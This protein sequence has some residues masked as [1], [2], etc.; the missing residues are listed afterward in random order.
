VAARRREQR[1]AA[2]WAALHEA[3]AAAEAARPRFAFAAADASPAAELA[4]LE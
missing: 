3:F 2:Q 4:R 1:E